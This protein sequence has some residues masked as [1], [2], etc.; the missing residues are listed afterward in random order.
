MPR[1]SP[2]V[3]EEKKEG[4]FKGLCV[5]RKER[6]GQLLKNKGRNKV[7]INTLLEV[8]T[9][10]RVFRARSEILIMNPQKNGKDYFGYLR[11]S[12]VLHEGREES[13]RKKIFYR[14]RRE[15][16]PLSQHL[17]ESKRLE[18]GKDLNWGKGHLSILRRGKAFAKL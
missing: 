14:R 11:H 17:P 7:K 3:G 6:L 8:L 2:P 13:R 12:Y 18:E 16:G 9:Q 5:R 15:M 10:R 4:I 1:L